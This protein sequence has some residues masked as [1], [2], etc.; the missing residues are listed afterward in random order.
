M[1]KAPNI[2]VYLLI[3]LV[4]IVEDSEVYCFKFFCKIS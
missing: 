2:I 1:V 3:Y 4:T